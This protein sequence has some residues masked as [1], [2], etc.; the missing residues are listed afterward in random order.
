MSPQAS[1][2]Y[3]YGY[4]F[5]PRRPGSQRKRGNQTPSV[6]EENATR[7]AGVAGGNKLPQTSVTPPPKIR[8]S[9]VTVDTTAES[10]SLGDAA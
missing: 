5:S 4:G 9:P 10:E 3:N 1:F 7:K 6:S 8:A 2:A